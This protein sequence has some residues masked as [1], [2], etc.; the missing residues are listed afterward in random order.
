MC[1]KNYSERRDYNWEIKG[2][3]CE[4]Q[5]DLLYVDTGSEYNASLSSYFEFV[6]WIINEL[7][8]FIYRRR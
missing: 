2:K 6:S 8:R 1:F 7:F 5:G 4:N 3:V